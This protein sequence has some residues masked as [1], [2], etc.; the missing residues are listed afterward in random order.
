VPLWTVLP[1]AGGKGKAK[2]EPVVADVAK[3]KPRRKSA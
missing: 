2:E 1:I 3:A